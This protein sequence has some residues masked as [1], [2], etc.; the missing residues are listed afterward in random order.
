MQKASQIH[1]YSKILHF[2]IRQMTQRWASIWMC[3]PVLVLLG[4][5]Q[6]TCWIPA[7]L[8]TNAK[9]FRPYWVKRQQ[10]RWWTSF[11]P[12]QLGLTRSS[13][14][15]SL[16]KGENLQ[17]RWDLHVSWLLYIIE[18]CAS[19]I[20]PQVVEVSSKRQCSAYFRNDCQLL[21]TGSSLNVYDSKAWVSVKPQKTPQQRHDFLIRNNRPY[22]VYCVLLSVWCLPA[23]PGTQP[24]QIEKRSKECP[25]SIWKLHQLSWPITTSK[26]QV[27]R[28]LHSAPDDA[29]SVMNFRQAQDGEEGTR[30]QLFCASTSAA[31]MTTM[32][33]VRHSACS[34]NSGTYLN[35]TLIGNSKC[36]LFQSIATLPF[37]DFRSL[38][39]TLTGASMC[40]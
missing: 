13:L 5:W 34:E 10:H 29:R 20:P 19:P 32:A 38:W 33:L 12:V 2:S 14:E 6:N 9:P 25:G 26:T 24:S 39:I 15:E 31:L 36:R 23:F 1:F 11:S 27:E 35:A 30:Q 40:K 28:V 4:S 3:T 16:K 21:S 8:W 37:L 22:S 17:P 7:R 18:I